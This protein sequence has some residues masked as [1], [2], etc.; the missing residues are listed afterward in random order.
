M[1]HF[2]KRIDDDTLLPT[3]FILPKRWCVP[4]ITLTFYTKTTN[5]TFAIIRK[6]R[7]AP[8][9]LLFV[10]MTMISAQDPFRNDLFK[11]RRCNRNDDSFC[12]CLDSFKCSN[13]GLGP[14][15]CGVDGSKNCACYRD[16]EN[17]S[18]CTTGCGIVCTSSE[19]CPDGEVCVDL[20]IASDICPPCAEGGVLGEPYRVCSKLCPSP[21]D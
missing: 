2:L 8:A 4:S 12:T 3:A 18:R 20:G 19:D 11:G 6:G 9:L 1:K 5:M 21:F 7:F 17:N 13:P 14:R 10:L 15:K 16:T